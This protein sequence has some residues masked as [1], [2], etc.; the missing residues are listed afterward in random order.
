MTPYHTGKVS[1]GSAYV[2]T[3]KP[4]HDKDALRLQDALLG[5]KRPIDTSGI[6]IAAACAVVIAIPIVHHF[7][8]QITRSHS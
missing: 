6:F 3:A 1:I 7:I 4:Y 2:P 5:N 8:N